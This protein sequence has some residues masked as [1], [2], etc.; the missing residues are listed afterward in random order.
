[1]HR[2]VSVIASLILAV[3]VLS[4]T[5]VTASAGLFDVTKKGTMCDTSSSDNQSLEWI[6]T[7]NRFS[8][9]ASLVIRGNGYMPNGTNDSWLETLYNSGC[10]LNSVTIESGVKSIMNDAF[11]GEIYLTKISLP[12]SIERIGDGAFAD[13][14]ITE[15]TIPEK[16]DFILPTMFN[17]AEMM[18]YNVNKNNPYYYSENGA[19][20]SADGST[21]V[22][23][24]CGRFLEDSNH[25]P[26][27]PKTVDTIGAC[28]FINSSAEYIK[29]PS[30]IKT[31][32]KQAFAGNLYLNE[33][34]IENGVEAIYDGAFLACSSLSSVRLPKSVTYLGYNSFGYEYDIAFEDIEAILDENGI[35]HDSINED[36][37]AYYM[38]LEPLKHYNIYE[39]VYCYPNKEFSVYAPLDSVGCNYA[40]RFG[41]K[42]VRS[43]CLEPKL[44]AA[45]VINGG[46]KVSW[47]KSGDATGYRV[48]RKS[49][50]GNWVMLDY[51]DNNSV[52]SF[53]DESPYQNY[54]NIYTVKALSDSGASTYN[55]T[56]I[57]AF[58]LKTPALTGIKTTTS[59]LRVSW[60]SVS[61]AQNYRVYRKQQ[62]DTKWTYITKTKSGVTTYDDTDVKN[63]V[64]YT[65][66]VRAVNSKGTS[67]YNSD[68]ISRTF[69]AAPKISSLSNTPDGTVIKWNK[70]SGAKIYRIY[71]KVPGGTWK[72][73]GDLSSTKSSYTDKNQKSGTVYQYTVRVYNGTAW[74]SYNTSSKIQFLST[75]VIL[76]PKST[77]DGVV[78]SYRKVTGAES[79][80]IYRKTSQSGDWVK[81]AD[82]SGKTTYTDKTA[83]KGTTYYY[84]V[85]AFN[86]SYK[87]G[88]SSDGV[89]IKDIY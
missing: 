78:I 49:K 71:R 53:I 56:G 89:K 54:K 46:V 15:I 79:Y 43:E 17:N 33:L 8:G 19:I 64:K 66:T 39:F 81:L 1:M 25:V 23:Y 76:T 65:Y 4:C 20:Y 24:P 62:G 31:I 14:G 80:R 2:V 70:I 34:V 72:E 50:N 59:G 48:Y 45:S 75:P 37:V 73:L 35:E 42:F 6:L 74:S 12:S 10:Y 61:G 77:K 5:C 44:L 87:S 82:V 85:R 3:S 13:T 32:R 16:V 67:S 9:E 60:S 83:K 40:Q 22:A 21:L 29:I 26:S 55:K 68:G 69:V 41:F 30:H 58:Y 27:I 88:Y 18:K 7:Y 63:G 47:T 57:S 52:T 28:A 36:N 38:S 11:N 86:G 51:I 84:T